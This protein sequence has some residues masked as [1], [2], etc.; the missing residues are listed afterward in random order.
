[1]REVGIIHPS[2]PLLFYILCN[3]FRFFMKYVR[4]YDYTAVGD[5]ETWSMQ[6]Q[7]RIILSWSCACQLLWFLPTTITLSVPNLYVHTEYNEHRHTPWTHEWMPY[8]TVGSHSSTPLCRV[9]LQ[10]TEKIKENKV[11][12]WY[13]W[14]VTGNFSD[15]YVFRTEVYIT[16]AALSTRSFLTI[17]ILSLFSFYFWRFYS[18][19]LLNSAHELSWLYFPS[20]KN[21]YMWYILWYQPVSQR[22]LDSSVTIRH[23]IRA[24]RCSHRIRAL[25][26]SPIVARNSGENLTRRGG[27]GN[28]SFIHSVA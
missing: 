20:A 13:P 5:L 16:R 11:G 14:D 12:K 1:M 25:S 4:Y 6:L 10:N 18:S 26:Y 23:R 7:P 21:E 3:L 27:T 19:T 2:S 24:I 9:I 28:N 8:H 15:S 22:Q 17:S